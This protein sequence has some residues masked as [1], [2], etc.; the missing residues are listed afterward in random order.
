MRSAHVLAL[1]VVLSCSKAPSKQP[2][3]EE[4]VV[5]RIGTRTLTVKDIESQLAAQPEFIRARFTTPERKREFVDSMVRTEL[6]LQEAERQGVDKRP[7]VRA[8]FEKLVVQQLLT[9]LARTS[10][11]TEA[12][13][14]AY[15]EQHLAEFSKPERVR[16]AVL[17]FGGTANAPPPDKALVQKELGRIRALKPVDQGRAFAALVQT[18]STHE[19]SRGQEGDVG[20]RTREELAQ[21]FSA[22]VADAAFM[23]MEPGAM[24]EPAESPRG[25]TV[26]RLIAKQPGEQRPF[27][28]E[29]TNL[30]MRLTAEARTKE[31]EKLVSSLQAQTKPTINESA[32]DKVRVGSAV[33]QLGP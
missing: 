22:Q 12:D 1:L 6:L 19:S 25:W 27:E 11:P 9:D 3:A 14:K 13:A 20:P 28:S 21:Q 18:K 15:Y 5:A 30:L 24:S 2:L 33:P 31:M 29:K 17:E 10:A 8:L 26:V 32:L 23:L 16:V 4:D 7:E